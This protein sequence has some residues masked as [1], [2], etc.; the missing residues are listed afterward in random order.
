MPANAGFIYL[1]SINVKLMMLGNPDGRYVVYDQFNWI[2]RWDTWRDA[3]IHADEHCAM[4]SPW[5]MPEI[6]IYDLEVEGC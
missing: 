1:C 6:E 5:D 4:F 2:G 3:E